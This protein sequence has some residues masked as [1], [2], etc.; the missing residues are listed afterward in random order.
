MY[1]RVTDYLQIVTV[2]LDTRYTIVARSLI[3][4]LKMRRSCHDSHQVC[5]FQ[6]H[7][8][9]RLFLPFNC[10]HKHNQI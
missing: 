7:H 1:V 3:V 10:L 6:M 4:I 2:R 5:G 8:I 9:L